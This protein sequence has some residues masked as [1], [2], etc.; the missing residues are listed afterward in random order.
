MSELFES[1]EK[2][3]P[4]PKSVVSPLLNGTW[5]LEYTTSDAILGRGGK[6]GL[7]QGGEIKVGQ[8][9]QIIGAN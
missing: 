2:L 7:F 8:V 9:L 4:T 6:G 5:V 1:L 3:N